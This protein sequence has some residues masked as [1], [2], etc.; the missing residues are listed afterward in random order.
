MS[1]SVERRNI[2][3]LASL[4]KMLLLQ[5]SS[6]VFG[7]D[8]T[9]MQYYLLAKIKIFRNVREHIFN[10]SLTLCSAD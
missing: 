7:N 10:P 2:S 8:V 1:C 9:L 4:R 3:F 5:K 6:L